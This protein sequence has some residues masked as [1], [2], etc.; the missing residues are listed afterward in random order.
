[1]KMK[2]LTVFFSLV[3]MV[4]LSGFSGVEQVTEEAVHAYLERMERAFNNR[5]GDAVAVLIAPEARIELE[6]TTKNGS[7]RMSLS[8]EEYRAALHGGLA[9]L[10]G[11]Q[12]VMKNKRI[13]IAE[14]AKS[15]DVSV[16]VVESYSDKG[17]RM[18]NETA[19]KYKLVLK[20]GKITA[21]L[22]TARGKGQ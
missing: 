19:C 14:D 10:D 11:Y 7:E 22:I 15:A 12:Y 17:K 8:R 2:T 21:V 18:I 13:M 5:D 9:Q 4:L 6:Q 16:K 3:L 1:M 20:R